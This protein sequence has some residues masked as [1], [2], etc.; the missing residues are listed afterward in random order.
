MKT[1]RPD[2]TRRPRLTKE[3]LRGLGFADLD[4][5][6]GGNGVT[7]G[8]GGNPKPIASRFCLDP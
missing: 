7:R 6:R 4:Q 8:A 3:T 2:E 1:R 5:V